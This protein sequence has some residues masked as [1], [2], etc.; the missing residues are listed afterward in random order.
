MPQRQVAQSPRFEE[1]MAA[2]RDKLVE[3]IQALVDRRKSI[4]ELLDTYHVTESTLLEETDQPQPRATRKTASRKKSTKGRGVVTKDKEGALDKIRAFMLNAKG[5]ALSKEEI[6]AGV[7]EMYGVE[8]PSSWQQM[9]YRRVRANKTFYN[10]EGR[11]GLIE[12]RARVETVS[13]VPETAT[14]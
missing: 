10:E 13:R 11:F 14:A 3:M 1:V 9:L 6:E 2:E 5:R 8:L 7:K 4:D 12:H